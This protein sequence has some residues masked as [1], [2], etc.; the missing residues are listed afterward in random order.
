[1][2]SVATSTNSGNSIKIPYF[3]AL[4]DNKDFTLTPRLYFNNDIL[5]QNEY[6]QVEK[7]LNHI[8]DFKSLKKLDKGS[9]SHFFSNSKINLNSNNFD[10]S[11]LEINIE[12]TSNDNFLK[13]EKLVNSIQDNQSLLNSF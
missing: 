8:T 7:N 1:M 12:K 5:I 9:K 2:P 13:V 6:R 10:Q 4:A 11:K 3:N